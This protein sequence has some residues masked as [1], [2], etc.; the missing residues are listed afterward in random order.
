M[1]DDL[2]PLRA[3]V[4]AAVEAAVP[5]DTATAVALAAFATAQGDCRLDALGMDSL[6]MMEFCIA[7]ELATQI[8]LTP[9]DLQTAE[10]LEAVLAAAAART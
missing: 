5:V 1:R 4:V 7:F 10:T 3:K 8:E 2:A 9:E 6:A